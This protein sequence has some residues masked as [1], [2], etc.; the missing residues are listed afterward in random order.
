MGSSKTE[1]MKFK[2]FLLT[3]TS[4]LVLASCAEL[5]S[6]LKHVEDTTGVETRDVLTN[7]EIVRGLKDALVHGT[8][9]AVT[10]L[11]NKNGYYGDAALKIWLPKE[12]KPVYE[13]LEKVPLLDK[14]IDDAILSLNRAAEAASKE[15][16]PIFVNAIRSMT[17]QEAMTILRGEENAATEYLKSKTYDQLY[18]AYLPKVKISLS[19][20]YVKGLS[21]EESYKKVID[22]YNTVSLNGMLWKKIEN[23]SLSEHT[24]NKALE[25]LF[26]KVAEEEKLI[27]QNPVHRVTD[28]LRR[29]FGFEF[30]D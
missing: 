17:I 26:V 3:L 22:T 9:T 13:R 1:R 15:A 2:S 29:V 12:A 11:H 7:E 20:E 27:R 25:G 21:A 14:Y 23:N 19:K 4:L 6:I 5:E 30:E 8:D 24:T 10:H 28:I 18:Q 16:A